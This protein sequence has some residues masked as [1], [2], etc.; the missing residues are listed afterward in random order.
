MREVKVQIRKVRT[1][2][3]D[4]PDARDDPASLGKEMDELRTD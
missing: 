3:Q 2:E 1:S 4:R